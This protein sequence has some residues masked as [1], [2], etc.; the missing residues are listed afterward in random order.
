MTN[1]QLSRITSSANGGVFSL[2]GTQVTF[3]AITLTSNF[4]KAFGG[5][6]GFLYL[7][8]T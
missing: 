8:N 2:T 6:G 3:Q 7:A 4:T 5:K 1:T